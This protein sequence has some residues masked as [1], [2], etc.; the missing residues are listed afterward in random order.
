[1]PLRSPEAAPPVLSYG[2]FY[3]YYDYFD[4]PRPAAALHS[5]FFTPHSPSFIATTKRAIA[6]PHIVS[7]ARPVSSRRSI[8]AA[9]Y[10]R[11]LTATKTP[12]LTSRSPQTV[13]SCTPPIVAIT[14]S[15]VFRWIPKAASSRASGSLQP[16]LRLARSTSTRKTNGWSL[17]DSGHTTCTFT[18]AI[19]KTVS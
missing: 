1:M 3:F 17:R 2:T 4:F 15:P 6:S 18:N 9:R 12:A 5:P 10:R 13:V 7:T 11:I 8:R 14:P 16:D 19:R